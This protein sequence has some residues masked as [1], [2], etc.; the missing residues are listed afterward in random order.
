MPLAIGIVTDIHSGPD[1]AWVGGTAAPALL[2]AALEHLEA[3]GATILVDLGDRL[4]DV[5]PGDDE[6]RLRTVADL[7]RATSLPTEHLRGNHDLLPVELQS[8]VLGGTLANRSIDVEGWHLS[9]LDTF[10][11]SIAGA[12]AP[13]TL[14]WLEADLA[15]TSLPTILFSHQPLDG[16]PL[17]G[18]PLFEVDFAAHAHPD[19]HEEAR[20]IIERAGIVRLAL[21]GHAHWNNLSRVR[22]VPYLSVQS[23]VARGSDGQA[24]GSHA[25]LE[26]DDE[27]IHV[28]VYGG[29]PFEVQL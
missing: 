6:A 10:D 25:L 20:R 8:G 16:A 9:F 19:A 26:L 29:E 14:A 13:A 21:N 22:G 28:R 5:A 23:L 4:N 15:A 12:L 27:R 7:F 2:A 3:L 17:V 18:N 1:L 11:G 24:A